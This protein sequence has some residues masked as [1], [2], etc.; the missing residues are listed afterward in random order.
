M[1]ALVTGGSPCWLD[2]SIQD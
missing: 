2:Q 1:A